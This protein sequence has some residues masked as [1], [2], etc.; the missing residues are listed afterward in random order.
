[1]EPGTPNVN[2]TRVTRF[3]HVTN[4]VCI[5]DIASLCVHNHRMKTPRSPSR[6]PHLY[7]RLGT[8]IKERRRQLGFT[9]KHLSD[10][11][12]ISRASL[13]NVETGRQRVLVH[14]L[15]HFAEKLDVN[16]T[17]LL[18]NPDESEELRN[19]DKLFF[20][21]NLSLEQRQQIARLLREEDELQSVS[22]GDHDRID[23]NSLEDTPPS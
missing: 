21:E 1:M 18:P 8:I 15:Y 9:Q 14:Q 16:V 11:L 22:G 23:R 17:A 4:N 20:S 12:G 2:N 5:L 3:V 6:T 13:A 7:R 10:Q 19:L